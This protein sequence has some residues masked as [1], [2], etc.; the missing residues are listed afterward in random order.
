MSIASKIV[1]LKEK[2][3][4][5]VRLVAV[6]KTHSVADILEAYNAGQR[7]FGESRAQEMAAKQRALPPDM[8]WHFIGPLQCNKVKDMASFV[9]TI[10]SV[11]SLRLL[12]EINKQAAKH[13]RIINVLLEIHIA[14]EENKHGFAPSE[15]PAIL[16]EDDLNMLRNIRICGLMGIATLTDEK[17]VMAQEFRSLHN[18]WSELKAELFNNN[19][20]FTEISMGM[21]ADYEI[22]VA[23][24]STMVRIGSFIFS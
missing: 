4:Q 20:F 17:D 5:N 11:D 19:P 13:S 22:A 2:L 24:G 14:K 3:P 23:E 1:F 6:S 8:E 21:T 12:G 15:C 10:H 16:R 18:L 7:I 9:H